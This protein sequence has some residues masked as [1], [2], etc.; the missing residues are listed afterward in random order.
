M[1]A[2]AGNDDVCSTCY[3]PFSAE[4]KVLEC[5]HRFHRSC[6]DAWDV[7]PSN[8]NKTCSYCRKPYGEPPIPPYR[9]NSCDYRYYINDW[10][11]FLNF[12]GVLLYNAWTGDEERE[13]FPFGGKFYFARCDN[14]Y[15][16]TPYQM[17]METIVANLEML[18]KDDLRRIFIPGWV[19]LPWNGRVP[20]SS[21]VSRR[22]PLRCFTYIGSETQSRY[23]GAILDQRLSQ[24][25]TIGLEAPGGVLRYLSHEEINT[26][27]DMWRDEMQQTIETSVENV[28]RMRRTS[29]DIIIRLE[30]FDRLF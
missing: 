18:R 6:F 9:I 20:R 5:G 24:C 14:N 2:D 29:S 8:V 25:E 30:M 15:R 11:A 4:V 21:Q 19:T 12:A 22:F 1:S 3:E 23:S 26:Y 17:F 27:N 10:N 16:E 28:L 7:S 13:V